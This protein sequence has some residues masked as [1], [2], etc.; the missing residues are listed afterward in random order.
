V[1]DQQR[2]GVHRVG[3]VWEGTV[4]TH[5]SIPF[6]QTGWPDF[7]SMQSIP[8]L[9]LRRI[10]HQQAAKGDNRYGWIDHHLEG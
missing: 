6:S 3:E 8:V 7:R 2:Q 9:G 10:Y 4:Y 1:L 5:R